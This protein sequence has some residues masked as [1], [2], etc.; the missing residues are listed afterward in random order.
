MALRPR[1]SK[2]SRSGS[3][4][5]SSAQ[6]LQA[7]AAAPLVQPCSPSLSLGDVAVPLPRSRAALVG[8]SPHEAQVARPEPPPPSG[9]VGACSPRAATPCGPPAAKPQGPQAAF[10]GPHAGNMPMGFWKLFWV[11]PGGSQ[12]CDRN[13]SNAQ[14]SPSTS[15][16][17]FILLFVF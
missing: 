8:Q 16:A 1:S 7:F 6:N 3:S 12:C 5:I 17:A 14:P 4:C 15:V 11:A 13:N 9:A 2:G 10:K